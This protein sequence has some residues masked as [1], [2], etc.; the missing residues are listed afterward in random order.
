M[1]LLV[2]SLIQAY[3][4]T[5]QSL[6]AKPYMANRPY[7]SLLSII[8]GEKPMKFHPTFNEFMR[9]QAPGY[10]QSLPRTVTIP[11]LNGDCSEIRVL[12]LEDAT[13]DELAFAIQALEAD[14]H[15]ICRRLYELQ[16]L[17]QLA[18]K[19]G[20]LGATTLN[21]AFRNAA[22]QSKEAS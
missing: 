9:Q 6:C 10:F 2:S 17:Y 22:E 7:R 12:L 19:R 14:R 15:D 11:S 1:I 3:R 5:K 18:R 20:V 21:D 16:D 4:N 8:T 13:L